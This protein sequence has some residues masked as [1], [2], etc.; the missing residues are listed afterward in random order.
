MRIDFWLPHLKVAGGT[1]ISLTYAS[2][3]AK[4]GHTVRV[5]T[6]QEGW[7]SFF[8]R[9]PT[10]RGIIPMQTVFVK[11]WQEA[12]TT[13]SDVV[14]ADSWQV[15]G[16]LA[17]LKPN[18]KLFHFIQHDERLYH[19]DASVVEAVYRSPAL[20]KIVVSTWLKEIFEKDFKTS[21]A[22]LLNTVDRTV[23]CPQEKL[24]AQDQQLRILMLVH[25]YLWKGTV[26]GV[27]LVERLKKKYPNVM[28]VG[29]GVREKRPPYALDEYHYNPNQKDLRDLYASADIFLCPSWDEGFGLPS[30]EAMAS[31]VALV[32]Y[33]NGGSRDFAYNEK[34]ALVAPRR[35]KEA[36]FAHLER[37]AENQELRKQIA[38]GG[39]AFV[40]T[41]PTWDEQTDALERIL[42][43]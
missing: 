13:E 18:K 29:F 38:S 19:G 2:L 36:L 12:S 9:K 24:R 7:L 27:A 16:A 40:E 8:S 20:G 10:W 41:L 21:P 34:T 5:F 37:L 22:F 35:D 30:L 1:K 42:M 31:G 39:R 43:K 32:T 17:E 11:N 3:L 33:D 28:L 6:P 26:E 4:R 14:V 25:P 23:F 15:G